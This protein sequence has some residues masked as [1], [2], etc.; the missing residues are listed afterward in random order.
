MKAGIEKSYCVMFAKISNS[1]FH[2]VVRQ[3]TEGVV[4]NNT[5]FRLHMGSLT[6]SEKIENLFRIDT[7]ITMSLVF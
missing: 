3:H 2:K 7:V 5:C 6:S 4:G 1:K